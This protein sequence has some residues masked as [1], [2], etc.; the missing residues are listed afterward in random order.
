MSA[1]A[2]PRPA[3][4]RS[5]DEHEAHEALCRRCGMSCHFAVPVNGLA[6]V[7]DALRCRF[8][9]RDDAG[10]YACTV[11]EQ[12]FARAPWCHTAD[13][14]LAGGFLAQDCPYARG[15]PGYRGK[16]RLSPA[17]LRKVLPAIRAEVARA[18]APIGADADAVAAFLGED[19][20]PAWG[21]AVSA[22]GNRYLFAPRAE[23]A[24]EGAGAGDAGAAAGVGDAA[25]LSG[26]RSPQLRVLRE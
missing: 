25:S 1:P 24:T 3:A 2:P 21:Y 10:R 5:R 18:G 6:V 16:V 14:A 11:Y 4:A 15:V 20:G 8:L 17:L 19:G 9:A 12:R 13:S 23:P 22:D 26:H 7:I